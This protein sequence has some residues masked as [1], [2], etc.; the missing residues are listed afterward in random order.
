MRCDI[1]HTNTQPYSLCATRDDTRPTDDGDGGRRWTGN[2]FGK[3]M[4]CWTGNSMHQRARVHNMQEQAM[5]LYLY[6]DYITVALPSTILLIRYMDGGGMRSYR[7]HCSAHRAT[8]DYRDLP[9]FHHRH[10]NNNN[11]R[12]VMI[13]IYFDF[14]TRCK[15]KKKMSRTLSW[16]C[17]WALCV[18]CLLNRLVLFILIWEWIFWYACCC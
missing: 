11:N 9:V 14:K 5:H 13:I 18:F 7:I 17:F 2:T 16:W 15:H 6:I 3:W 12:K 8:T 10:K 1:A 4:T